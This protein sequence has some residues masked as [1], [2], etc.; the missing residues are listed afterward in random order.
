MKRYVAPS[1]RLRTFNCPNCGVYANQDWKIA[2][3]KGRIKA[4]LNSP[5]YH[6]EG[7]TFAFC[8]SC[9]D[10]SLW[11]GATMIFPHGGAPLSQ[12]PRYPRRTIVQSNTAKAICPK[13]WD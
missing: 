11:L 8:T 7:L 12:N 9:R 2:D 13:S 5:E 6:F 1:L 4:P 3:Y 10:Y